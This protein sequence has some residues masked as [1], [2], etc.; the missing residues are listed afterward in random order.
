M[1]NY[2]YRI[3]IHAFPQI[4]FLL[5]LCLSLAVVSCGDDASEEIIPDNGYKDKIELYASL[6]DYLPNTDFL[7]GVGMGTDLYM[8]D[9]LY[10]RVVD[11]NF[12]SMTFENAMKQ[13]CVV[14]KD[15]KYHFDAIDNVLEKLPDNFIVYGHNLIWHA[16]Q[17]ADYLNGLLVGKIEFDDTNRKNLLQNGTFDEGIQNWIKFNG[18]EGCATWASDK[19]L[20]GGGCLQVVNVE[21]LD[22]E[23]KVQVYSDLLQ[24]VIKDKTLYISFYIRTEADTEGS[25]RLSTG[26]EKDSGN[27]NY[28]PSETVDSKWKRVDWAFTASGNV[29]GIKIDLGKKSGIYLIDNIIVSLE[30]PMN[31]TVEKTD[32]EKAQIVSDAMESWIKSMIGHYKSRIKMWEVL[33]EPISDNLEI[34]G[35]ESVPDEVNSDN[36]FYGKFLGKE[37]AIKAF[38]WAKEADPTALLFINDYNLEYNEAKCDKLLEFVNYIEE[39][40][41]IVDGIGTQM[42]IDISLDKQKIVKMFEKLKATGKLI[43]ISELDIKV[44]TPFPSEQILK[45]QA[46]MYRYVIRKYLEII[47][48]NQQ[49]GITFWLL[50]DNSK[51]HQYWIPNDAP[52]LFDA[53]Y[54]RKI[55]YKGVCDGLQGRDIS[56]DFD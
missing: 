2:Q 45:I 47:P 23:W 37:Y 11:E 51:E 5:Y 56:L 54:N 49:A 35:V 3:F 48:K 40:G 16:Q 43:R 7:I 55:A 24:K 4:R 52:C 38:K 10:S 6:K 50:S 22:A 26:I 21:N 31:L 36:F 15:G 20:D 42:H 18:P 41:A 12:N 32:E 27:E 28:Q 29:K 8:G 46:E 44:K 30:P 39:G 53:S 17:A 34:R 14:D 25:V 19:G 13:G 33:N 1:R 9:E